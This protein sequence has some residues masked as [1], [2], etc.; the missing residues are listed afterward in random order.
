MR[1]FRADLIKIMSE[2]SINTIMTRNVCWN[3]DTL[4]QKLITRTLFDCCHNIRW[5]SKMSRYCTLQL[6][7]NAVVQNQLAC[8]IISVHQTL[9]RS[10][11]LSQ[12]PIQRDTTV[13]YH[14]YLFSPL[15]TF[16][17]NNINVGPNSHTVFIVHNSHNNVGIKSSG[18]STRISS[19]HWQ[20]LSPLMLSTNASLCINVKLTFLSITTEMGA[21]RSLSHVRIFRPSYADLMVITLKNIQIRT[22]CLTHTCAL[23][24]RFKD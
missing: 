17:S 2:S 8:T 23:C 16:H 19:K 3:T 13:V 18:S 21:C 24:T 5:E 12:N 7:W 9:T 4:Y 6:H 20:H 11:S 22:Q 15:F 14:S 1:Q 10:N